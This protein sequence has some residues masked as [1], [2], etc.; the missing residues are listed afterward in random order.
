[1]KASKK[2]IYILQQINNFTNLLALKSHDRI[3][4]CKTER[5]LKDSSFK[6]DFEIRRNINVKL[7]N[8]AHSF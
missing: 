6:I 2:N 4:N 7:C 3:I 1:M 5:S 8:K